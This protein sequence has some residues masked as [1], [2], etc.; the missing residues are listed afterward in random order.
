M[1]WDDERERE[2]QRL[3]AL[4]RSRY[5]SYNP[6]MVSGL[7]GHGVS[8]SMQA[9]YSTPNESVLNM[10]NSPQ[11]QSPLSVLNQEAVAGPTVNKFTPVGSD[12]SPADLNKTLNQHYQNVPSNVVPITP[13]GDDLAFGAFGVKQAPAP[14]PVTPPGT[15]NMLDFIDRYGPVQSGTRDAYYTKDGVRNAAG[16]LV[17][18]DPTGGAI[19]QNMA[20]VLSNA[21]MDNL[22]AQTDFTPPVTDQQYI[23]EGTIPP[24]TPLGS[25]VD[26]SNIFLDERYRDDPS[27]DVETQVDSFSDMPSM[28]PADINA[29]LSKAY[30][31]T[32]SVFTGDEVDVAFHTDTP[33]KYMEGPF[34]KYGPLRNLITK[35]ALPVATAVAV[36]DAIYGEKARQDAA[37]IEEATQ[38]DSFA[39]GGQVQPLPEV[40]QERIKERTVPAGPSAA[41][42]QRDK[43]AAVDARLAQQAAARLQQQQQMDAEIARQAEQARQVQAAQAAKDAQAQALQAQ[44]AYA[45][46]K[47]QLMQGR[48]RGEP[49]A[50]EIERAMERATQVDT[51]GRLGFMGGQV[52]IEDG[53]G[54]TGG[55]F[56]SGAGW[57]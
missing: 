36:V 14:L 23:N 55:D 5:G 34:N 26:R 7:L 52:G 30:T 21:N 20:T 25:N 42:V 28:A 11:F 37:D 27:I 33:S 12:Y 49:S 22:Y 54:Y 53:G 48:D 13:T 3:E 41:D 9:N 46:M 4:A 56:S 50:R 18:T 1:A 40:I 16:D 8:P 39:S 31:G 10:W 32:D 43:Q 45:A 6:A 38:V 57:E 19:D 44:L 51:F 35:S 17:S 29:M 15:M 24:G 2:R 47:S